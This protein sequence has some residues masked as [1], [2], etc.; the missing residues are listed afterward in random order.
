[1]SLSAAAASWTPSAPPAPEYQQLRND[2]H[3]GVVWRGVGRDND[4][5]EAEDPA[6]P[7]FRSLLE[8][9]FYEEDVFDD[10]S[11]LT[12]GTGTRIPY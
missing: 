10:D 2:G 6:D 3:G 7:R 1:M 11:L 8:A 5:A 9:D 12:R 4:S